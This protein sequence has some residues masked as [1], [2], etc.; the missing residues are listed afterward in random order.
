MMYVRRMSTNT[1][2][3]R[4][5][6]HFFQ[7]SLIGATLK[8]YMSLDSVNIHTF[9]DSGEVFIRKYKYNMDMAPDRD[10]LRAMVQKI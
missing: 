7:D 2:D 8:W 5:L 4:L 9:N 3:Q 1:D 6:I 10:Q